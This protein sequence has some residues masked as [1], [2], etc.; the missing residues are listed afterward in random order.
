[1]ALRVIG[2]LIIL[3]GAFAGSV[4]FWAPEIGPA[5]GMAD[6]PAWE[7]TNARFIRHV[8]P[9][10]AVIVGGALL[11]LRSRAAWGIG[12]FLA[13]IGAAWITIAP[14]V[15]G[16][17]PTGPS[18]E[19]VAVIARKLGHHFAIGPVILALATFAIGWFA[20]TS[21]EPEPTTSRVSERRSDER[22]PVNA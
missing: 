4:P 5:F 3:L 18:L 10:L 19:P 9:A 15:L 11:L 8:A 16:P 21:R 7:W 2:T 17:V 14:V 13:V 6:V 22:Q 20:A 12:A 1:M